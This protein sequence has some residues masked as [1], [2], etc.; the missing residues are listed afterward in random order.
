MN[1][2]ESIPRSPKIMMGGLVMV[3]RMTDKAR[4]Y[5]SN[6]LGEYI[7][8]CPLDKI[9]LEFLDTNH[10]EF[11]YQTK[12]LSDKEMSSWIE[13]KCLH[14]SKGDKDRINKKLLDRKPDTRESLNCFKEIQNKLSPIAKNVTTWIELIELEESQTLPKI[15]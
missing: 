14:R 4:A 5:N 2:V 6:T 12:N 13:E 15:K 8:P 11:A 3:P 10:K 7:F 1:L 9:I